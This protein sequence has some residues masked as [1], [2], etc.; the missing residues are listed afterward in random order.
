MLQQHSKSIADRR[1]FHS[2]TAARSWQPSFS[3]DLQAEFVHDT[4]IYQSQL[5]LQAAANEVCTETCN[6]QAASGYRG[7]AVKI[8]L[9]R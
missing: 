9:N 8:F 2:K 7:Q 5:W 1:S 4:T 3:F 6:P